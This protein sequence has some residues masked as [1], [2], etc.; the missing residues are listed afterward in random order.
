MADHILGPRARFWLAMCDAI[1]WLH[2]PISWW[3]WTLARANAAIDY[4]PEEQDVEPER[5]PW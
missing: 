5:R 3:R 1:Y 2:L 4:G